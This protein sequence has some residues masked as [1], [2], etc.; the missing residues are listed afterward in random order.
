VK[1][2]VQNLRSGVLELMEVPCARAARGHVLIQ[3]R[4][5]V[6]SAGTERSLVE[7]GKAS[8]L[9]KARQ[10]PERVKQVLAKIKADGLL[11]TLEAVFSRLDEPLPLGYCNAGVVVEVGSGVADLAVGDRVASNGHHAQWVHVPHRLCARI[12]DQVPDDEAAFA[13]LGSIALQGIRLLEPQLGETVVVFGLGLVGLIAIQL[14]VASGTRVIGIDLDDQR[15]RLAEA[16]GAQTINPREGADP[17]A[18]AVGLTH[19]HGVDAVLITASAKDDTIISQ[20]AQMSRKR[21]RLV[22]VGV[23]N[24]ELNR[25][26]FYEK[27]LT[28][29]VSCSYG[30]GRYDPFYEQ[31]GNDYPRAFVR[32]TEQ[33]NIQAV[34]ELIERG[35]LDVRRLISHRIEFDQALEAYELL[36]SGRSQLGVVLTYPPQKSH[37]E[38]TVGLEVADSGAAA[39]AEE[40]SRRWTAVAPSAPARRAVVGVIGAGGFT[41]GV[42]LPALARTEA[43]LHTIVSAGGL[44][45]AHAARKFGFKNCS[46]DYHALLADSQINTVVITTRHHQ[47]ADMVVEALEAGKHVFVEKPLA[48]D[49][50]GLER[51]TE[52]YQ[53]SSGQQLM[54]GFNRRFAPF[55]VQL[56]KLLGGRTG[57]LCMNMLVNAGNIPADHWVHD[58][59]I[60]GGR[61]IGEGCHWID[62]LSF[63]ADSPVVRVHADHV[64]RGGAVAT[65]DD[66]FS[67][68]LVLA[69]GSIGSVHYFANGHRSFP[70]ERLT[71]FADG[72]VLEMDNYRRLTGF[73]IAGF[74]SA[75]S[76]RQDKGHLAE[77]QQWIERIVKGGEPLIPFA[78]LHNVTAASFRCG[79]HEVEA[80]EP[81]CEPAH[82]GRNGGP[83]YGVGEGP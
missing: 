81:I 63:L 75:K 73:G 27:E 45:A 59:E 74:R 15:L 5:S 54:V 41:K 21:G 39:S 32:W 7:F 48:I 57:P 72:K 68:S 46:T 28:F 22:L 67:I 69:D 38:R 58:P 37:P 82:T 65:H 31:Q 53:R 43:E 3:S 62:L 35:R 56:K 23:V 11:P 78:Q 47:H 24:L 12:P 64:G 83:T 14:L 29:Q 49:A 20:A 70:K 33:R 55:I 51:V 79:A 42:L 71:V 52:A 19:G 36:S 6:I 26:E 2:V 50:E 77:C 25:A 4:A 1:Q 44:S 10:N 76:F 13:V 17:V 61:L 80:S 30:P 60:G 18:A 40:H 16:F 9:A 66:H 8:L 34:L